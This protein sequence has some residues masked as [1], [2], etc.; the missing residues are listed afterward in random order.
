[1]HSIFADQEI[2][3]SCVILKIRYNCWNS[4]VI[5]CLCSMLVVVL[6]HDCTW[7]SATPS[8]HSRVMLSVKR[9]D[10]TSF[11]SLCKGLPSSFVK[12]PA[13]AWEAPK[14]AEYI[15]TSMMGSSNEHVYIY[16]WSLQ[17]EGFKMPC[18]ICAMVAKELNNYNSQQTADSRQQ[19][20]NQK[21]PK[22]CATHALIY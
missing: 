1:M 3:N 17:S 8:C 18:L 12:L 15:L 11:C 5:Y 16:V 20:S 7:S 21:T 2:Y 10:L 14:Q 19:Y 22:P 9:C 4:G 6:V 13:F